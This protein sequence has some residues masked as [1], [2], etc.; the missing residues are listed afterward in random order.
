MSGEG[1][2]S[3]RQNK[4]LEGN[5]WLLPTALTVLISEA[6]ALNINQRL[7]WTALCLISIEIGAKENILAFR[8]IQRDIHKKSFWI[9]FILGN[10]T[11][12]TRFAN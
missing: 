4:N 3:G 2:E 9:R 7:W 10:R 8:N 6:E 5:N 11:G 1:L 12:P